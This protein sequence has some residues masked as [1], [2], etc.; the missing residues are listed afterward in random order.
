MLGPVKIKKQLIITIATFIIIL[1]LIFLSIFYSDRQAAILAGDQAIASDIENGIS[2]LN[3]VADTYFL[4]QQD[5]QLQ[6]WQ[7]NITALYG[8][9]EQLNSTGSVPIRSCNKL[10]L[11]VQNVNASFK[12]TVSYLQKT[13]T[14]T[15]RID[16]QFQAVWNKLSLSLQTLSNDSTQLSQYLHSQTNTINNSNIFLIITLLVAFA[17][18]LIISYFIMFR[19]TLRTISELDAGVKIIGTG[20][21]EHQIKIYKNDELGDLS[22]SVNEMRMQ[23]KKITTQ[24]KE[25]ERLAG[26]GQTAGMVGHDLRNP[27]QALVGEVYLI[28][29]ELK[30]LPKSQSRENLKDSV[31]G[32]G[33]QL[34]YMDKIVSDL[35]TFVKPV[36]VKKEPVNMKQLISM[37]LSLIELPPTIKLTVSVE[38]ELTVNTDPQLLKRVLVNLANNAIQAMPNGGALNIAAKKAPEGKVQLMVQDTGVGIPD[39]IKPKIFTPLFTTKSRGQGFGLAVC[40]RVI[41][42]QNGTITFES[43]E[44]KGATFIIELP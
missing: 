13:S 25:Q 30:L 11:D 37:V 3:N 6:D 1:G 16:P 21:F 29:E 31:Q 22:N 10:W 19:R 14:E 43:Q 18:Y 24:L 23:L 8:Y 4:Y 36:E 41:E 32:I 27:L 20:D 5:V 12:I 17:I 35:Q 15:P 7:S 40:K 33:E 34:S 44:G 28:E 38:E 39:D 42:A 2:N 26:I 9:V